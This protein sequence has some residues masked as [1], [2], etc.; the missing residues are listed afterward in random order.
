MSATQHEDAVLESA[1]GSQWGLE[2]RGL[3]RLSL[4]Y[5][6]RIGSG[7]DEHSGEPAIHRHRLER[8]GLNNRSRRIFAH[9]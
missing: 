8:G 9:A 6:L 7:T 4:A 5:L 2:H 1:Y 3:L